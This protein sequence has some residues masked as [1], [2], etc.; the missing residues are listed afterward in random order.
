MKEEHEDIDLNDITKDNNQNEVNSKKEDEQ[1]DKLQEAQTGK[2]GILEDLKGDKLH[3]C[4][5]F[6]L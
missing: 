6:F 5:L 4:I 3:V 2:T 1:E